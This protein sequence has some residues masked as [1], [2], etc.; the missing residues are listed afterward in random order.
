M[1]SASAEIAEITGLGTTFVG[2]TLVAIVTSL[3]EMVT[4]IAAVRIGADDMAIGNLFG[5]N[6][7]NMFA[8]GLTDMFYLQG[9]FLGII[10]PAFLLVGMLGLLMT[11][12]GL[13]GNLARLERRVLFIELDALALIAIYFAGLWLLYLRGVTP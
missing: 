7:F 10:D 11:G 3:P 2:T 8:I 5:S 9:R 1:V 13:I 6:L 12:M 4:T